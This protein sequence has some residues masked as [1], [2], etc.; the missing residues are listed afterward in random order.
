MST[1]ITYTS[2]FL[3]G[4]KRYIT[5][6]QKYH[7]TYLDNMTRSGIITLGIRK[8]WDEKKYQRSKGGARIH[9][10]IKT[11]VTEV[12]NRCMLAKPARQLDLTS[13]ITIFLEGNLARMET[14]ESII[15]YALVNCQSVV[16][17]TADIQQDLTENNFTLCA[18][19]ETWIRQDDGVTPVQLCPP[20]FK[21]IS[22][23]RNDK[24]GGGIAVVYKDTITARS[25][26]TYCTPQWNAAV[27]LWISLCQPLICQSFIDHQTLVYWL[28]LWISWIFWRII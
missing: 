6:A 5:T 10:K 21:V 9:I 17:K 3:R 12:E 8:Y 14:K 16:N 13:I 15:K 25:R 1:C 20:G 4:I 27:S 18:L 7:L 2:R 19:T 26:A 23:S 22:I 24:T 28:L 11:M